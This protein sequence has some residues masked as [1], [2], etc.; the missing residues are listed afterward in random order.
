[1]P[2]L[3]TG[4]RTNTAAHLPRQD[5]RPRLTLPA[6]RCSVS[7]FL[8]RCSKRAY[9]P[10]VSG[11]PDRWIVKSSMVSRRLKQL[12]RS[13]FRRSA[14]HDRSDCLLRYRGLQRVE[15]VKSAWPSSPRR[16]MRPS[17]AP[18]DDASGP[19][20]IA[21]SSESSSSACLY[22]PPP[23]RS[24]VLRGFQT[25]SSITHSGRPTFTSQW[26]RSTVSRRTLCQGTCTGHSAS[27]ICSIPLA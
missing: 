2:L 8:N 20:C 14:K 13:L 9:K 18:S 27:S 22:S 5:M 7:D 3:P 26:R 15:T 23:R 17:S 24:P 6:L 4:T 1:M 12:L 11:F 21:G 19:S 16:P 25:G 10:S